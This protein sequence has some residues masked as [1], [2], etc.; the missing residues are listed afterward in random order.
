MCN[1]QTELHLFH[2]L[3]IQVQSDQYIP[4]ED[5]YGEM[6]QLEKQ[7]DELEQTGVELEKKLRDNPNGITQHLPSLKPNYFSSVEKQQQHCTCTVTFS[8]EDEERL[9]VDWFTL[10]HEKHLLVRREAELV[11]T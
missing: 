10:I 1:R 2:S 11:Y 4:V 9:L 5:I 8:D 3:I 6:S 7:L